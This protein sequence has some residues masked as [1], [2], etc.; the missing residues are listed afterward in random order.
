MN[1]AGANSD[2]RDLFDFGDSDGK[3]HK[4]KLQHP[5]GV[6]F[7]AANQTLYVADTYNHK[8][9]IM[10]GAEDGVA[11]SREDRMVTWLG[12]SEDKNARVL[13]GSLTSARLNEPNG[14][15]AKTGSNGFEGLYIA[16]TGNDCIRFAHAD[17]RV[18]TLELT[19]VPD[20][21]STAA[22]CQ[23]GVCTME[24]ESKE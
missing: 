4:A 2:A 22:N 8:I 18:E 15:W 5:L 14:C 21:R 23:G 17:G 24:E 9:K 6:H 20:V 19:G 3:G 13:D 1:V 7:C 16:D 11:L 10:K 12:D